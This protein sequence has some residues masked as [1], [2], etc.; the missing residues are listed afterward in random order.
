M[1]KKWIKQIQGV[2]DGELKKKKQTTTKI[3]KKNLRD[4]SKGSKKLNDGRTTWRTPTPRLIKNSTL[5]RSL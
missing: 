1:K 2:H 5:A 3:E 4:N